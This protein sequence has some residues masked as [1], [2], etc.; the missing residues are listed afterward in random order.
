[1]YGGNVSDRTFDNLVNIV[2]HE[3][4]HVLQGQYV[5]G[6]ETL[7]EDDGEVAWS[8]SS[9]TF[10]AWLVEGA[11][12]YAD[13]RYSTPTKPGRRAFLGQRY[14]PYEDLAWSRTTN[15]ILDDPAAALELVED[16]DACESWPFG[17]PLGFLATRYAVEEVAKATAR[18]RT[19]GGSRES[20]RIGGTPST[21]RSA[22][23]SRI[24]MKASASGSTRRT[25]PCL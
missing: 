21:P 13:F 1:M 15:P 3:Y 18:T 17:Y 7:D 5:A 14:T 19:S 10:P 2:A 22:S 23:R 20:D 25:P 12:S 8:L 9:D 16:R 4:F 11:A 24:S 6:F